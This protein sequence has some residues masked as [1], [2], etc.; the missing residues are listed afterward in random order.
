MEGESSHNDPLQLMSLNFGGSV[1]NHISRAPQHDLNQKMIMEAGSSVNQTDAL[2]LPWMVQSPMP[3]QSCVD[4]LA[5]SSSFL[6]KSPYEDMLERISLSGSGI[7]AAGGVSEFHRDLLYCSSLGKASGS[8]SI[9]F[10]MDMDPWK[11]H[12]SWTDNF[13]G[14]SFDNV[15]QVDQKLTL[16]APGFPSRPRQSATK[17]KALVTD[18][19]ARRIRIAERVTALEELL[20]QS[21]E[22]GQELVLDDV[23]D[24]IKFLQLQIKDLSKSRLGGETITEPMIFR[25]GYG[26]YFLHQQMLSE[27]LEEMIGKLLETNPA[28]ADQLLKDKGLSMVPLGLTKK[29]F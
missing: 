26:H 5:E 18:R 28:A 29:L 12:T 8:K 17:Q 16:A 23:I 4:F 19:Q 13:T 1:A 6:P 21:V 2:A 9:D 14:A 7:H 20:P 11:H 15:S 25:E 24:H 10:S 22:G 3:A 27:P